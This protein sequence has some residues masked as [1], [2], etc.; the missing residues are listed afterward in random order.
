MD[1][2]FRCLFSE[3][4]NA[5]SDVQYLFFYADLVIRYNG[6][7]ISRFQMLTNLGRFQLIETSKIM[8]AKS[9]NK[10]Q[11]CRG[12]D[13]CCTRVRVR[14]TWRQWRERNQEVE[15]VKH[16]PEPRRVSLRQWQ[17]TCGKSF[18]T[19]AL[20]PSEDESGRNDACP[21]FYMN[22]KMRMRKFVNGRHGKER[23]IFSGGF[24]LI[25]AIKR[26]IPHGMEKMLF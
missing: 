2:F 10:T 13:C 23:V 21:E 22:T 19:F 7:F 15:R 20:N 4:F 18:A 16:K 26:Q 24:L 12:R 6:K 14:D 9:L 17:E 1:N 3:A 25:L 5:I 11:T 8:S